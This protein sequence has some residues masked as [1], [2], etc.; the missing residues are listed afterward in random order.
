MVLDP[1]RRNNPEGETG[2]EPGDL[3]SL[4]KYSLVGEAGRKIISTRA[5]KAIS[6]MLAAPGLIR[7]LH[8]GP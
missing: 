8:R 5:S 3:L 7:G 4:L 1:I 2:M 6:V